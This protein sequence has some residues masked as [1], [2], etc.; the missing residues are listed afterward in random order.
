V[1]PGE[2]FELPTNG[3]Q[4]RFQTLNDLHNSANRCRFDASKIIWLL[5]KRKPN[6][7]DD[8]V[9]VAQGFPPFKMPVGS[10]LA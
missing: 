3:L 5:E 1:V 2:R 4:N 8:K 7:H 10:T 6:S 9:M